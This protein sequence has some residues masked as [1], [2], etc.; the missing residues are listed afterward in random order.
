MARWPHNIVCFFVTGIWSILQRSTSRRTTYV[1]GCELYPQHRQLMSCGTSRSIMKTKMRREK[2][3]LDQIQICN[4]TWMSWINMPEVC[5]PG[6]V[7]VKCS[8][9]PEQ[10]TIFRGGFCSNL[11]KPTFK[12]HEPSIFK[13][14]YLWRTLIS[15]ELIILLMIVTRKVPFESQC[16]SVASG[17][18]RIMCRLRSKF[19]GISWKTSGRNDHVLQ[20]INLYL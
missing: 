17:S 11:N 8:V 7:D 9:I 4:S 18:S 6:L 14:M 20:S 2:M 1:T 16:F 19:K 3:N 10:S 12:K 13:Y 5:V 15:R